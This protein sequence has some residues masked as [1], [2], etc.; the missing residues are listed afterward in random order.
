MK[1][2]KSKVR[3]V[4]ILAEIR[5]FKVSIVVILTEIWKSKVRVAVILAQIRKSKVR[6]VAMLAEI[7]KSKV[8][9]VVMLAEIRKSKVRI[10][11]MLAEIRTEHLSNMPQTLPL[12]RGARGSVTGW[13]T[14]LQTGRSRFRVPMRSLNIFNWPNTSSR[15]MAL[16]S[17]QPLTE[18]STRKISVGVKGGRRVRLTSLLPSVSR[19][20]R[21]C[22]NLAFSLPHGPSR[23][24]TRAALPLPHD[25]FYSGFKFVLYS[26]FS[27]SYVP[28]ECESFYIRIWDN[29]VTVIGFRIFFGVLN[30]KRSEHSLI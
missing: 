3:I 14:M 5:K 21:K 22:G 13:S 19:L 25:P 4:V 11:V 23:P 7:R 8:R 17:I 30:L 10:V 1:P 9:I 15:T 28:I 6:I 27:V 16:G 18:M 29:F 2:R 24:V 12:D 20:Y 26:L